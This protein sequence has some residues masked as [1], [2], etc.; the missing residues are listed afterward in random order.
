MIDALEIRLQQLLG[1]NSNSKQAEN[2]HEL[3]TKTYKQALKENKI[4]N[5][6]QVAAASGDANVFASILK[7]LEKK[8]IAD[9]NKWEALFAPQGEDSP[10]HIA[11]ESHADEIAELIVSH[12]RFEKEFINHNNKSK[13]TALHVASKVPVSLLDQETL[14][15]N[16]AI[17]KLLL[18]NSA[19]VELADSVGNTALHLAA[20]A[21]K[22]DTKTIFDKNSRE[23]EPVI[24]QLIKADT[25]KQTLSAKNTQGNTPLHM[26]F[27]QQLNVIT[28]NHLLEA[29]ADLYVEN[30]EGEFPL[31]YAVKSLAGYKFT[32]DL[33][34]TIGDDVVCPAQ[35]IGLEATASLTNVIHST[36]VNAWLG[37]SAMTISLLS[38]LGLFG[39]SAWQ[40]YRFDKNPVAQENFILS[41]ELKQI[42]LQKRKITVKDEKTLHEIQKRYSSDTPFSLSRELNDEIPRS[43]REETDEIGNKNYIQKLERKIQKGFSKNICETAENIIE[44]I[45]QDLAVLNT[46]AQAIEQTLTLIK[47]LNSGKEFDISEWENL[48]PTISNSFLRQLQ[49]Q[50]YITRWQDKA[51][52]FTKATGVAI[53][54]SS[55]GFETATVL[56][57]LHIPGMI[58]GISLIFGSMLS[59]MAALVNEYQR[60]LFLKAEIYRK[61]HE[62]K[63]QVNTLLHEEN[64]LIQQKQKIKELIGKLESFKTECES[65]KSDMAPDNIPAFKMLAYKFKINQAFSSANVTTSNQAPEQPDD[66]KPKEP[67]EKLEFFNDFLYKEEL[68]HDAC[69]NNDLKFVEWILNNENLKAICLNHPDNHG[70]TPLHIAAK[71]SFFSKRKQRFGRREQK[72]YRNNAKIIESLLAHGANF[73][74][75][76][77]YGNTPLHL[78]ARTGLKSETNDSVVKQLIAKDSEK[79]TINAKNKDGQTPLH[80]AFCKHFNPTTAIELIKAGAK[81]FDPHETDQNNR[82][83]NSAIKALASTG[84]FEDITSALGESACPAQVTAANVAGQLPEFISNM[85][86]LYWLGPLVVVVGIAGL[87]GFFSYAHWKSARISKDETN[88]QNLML[89]LYIKQLETELSMSISRNEIAQLKQKYSNIAP[90]N[91]VGVIKGFEQQIQQKILKCKTQQEI[92]TLTNK[93][94]NNIEKDIQLLEQ[95]QN[96]IKAFMDTANKINGGEQYDTSQWRGLN[97]YTTHVGILREQSSRYVLSKKEMLWAITKSA[98]KGACFGGALLAAAQV[99]HTIPFAG[100][101]IAIGFSFAAIVAGVIVTVNEYRKEIEEIANKHRNNHRAKLQINKLLDKQ[102]EQSTLRKEIEILRENLRTSQRRLEELH[103]DPSAIKSEE[104]KS[105]FQFTCKPENSSSKIEPKHSRNHTSSF[106]FTTPPNKHQNN[107]TPRTLILLK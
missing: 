22:S 76:D 36:S 105:I 59:S 78:A 44:K 92:E 82:L 14:A 12:P 30:R 54:F 19:A 70:Q 45:K 5:I 60:D 103:K 87:F 57:S 65:I 50:E 95:K 56:F 93:M 21:G 1:K 51:W 34:A 13:Q 97:P 18:D 28:A 86:N 100:T 38:A 7:A 67:N 55:A 48:D 3:F 47:K 94:L 69:A 63:V 53:C 26:A 4:D 29:G 23:I 42:E 96:N 41:F 25:E 75:I 83:Q 40:T 61:N 15:K 80:L 73:K 77:K 71:K 106:L 49:S 74:L 11:A 84:H 32:Q 64:G 6:L 9:S 17:V 81:I 24:V 62:E 43:N 89:S 90:Q 33:I 52:S 20:Q 85:K 16:S 31:S 91:S 58:A 8:L 10:L 98:A 104:R 37:P 68:L 99:F 72:G 102:E 39:A 79:Q 107:Q 35:Y 2:P 27:T 88:Q 101:A 46:S 66:E